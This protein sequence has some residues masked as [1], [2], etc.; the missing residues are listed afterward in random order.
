MDR[1]VQRPV[2]DFGA[3]RRIGL[4]RQSGRSLSPAAA[5]FLKHVQAHLPEV[6]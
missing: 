3:K 4:V 1:L 6:Q 5:A 2:R